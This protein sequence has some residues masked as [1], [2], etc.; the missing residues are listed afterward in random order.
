MKFVISDVLKRALLLIFCTYMYKLF[1]ISIIQKFRTKDESD[2]LR[3][4]G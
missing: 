3:F 1:Y 2:S 4:L